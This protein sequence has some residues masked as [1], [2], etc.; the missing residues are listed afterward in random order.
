MLLQL[1]RVTLTAE[2]IREGTLMSQPGLLL[3][4][5]AWPHTVLHRY[6]DYPRLKEQ[7]RETEE[8]YES[9]LETLH[10]RHADIVEDLYRR[11]NSDG[12]A[13]SQ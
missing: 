4:L 11:Q 2:A 7:L 5:L 6:R 12:E 10:Q 13:G 3:R 1:V 8:K 9:M